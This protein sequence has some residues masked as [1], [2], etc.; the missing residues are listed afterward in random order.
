MPYDATHWVEIDTEDLDGC[1]VAVMKF[2]SLQHIGAPPTHPLFVAAV[3]FVACLEACHITWLLTVELEIET[4]MGDAWVG[5]SWCGGVTW[6]S[7]CPITHHVLQALN[8]HFFLKKKS[9][10]LPR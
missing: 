2:P 10:I 6:N 7:L 5:W 1:A 4:H 9:C 8:F 3:V